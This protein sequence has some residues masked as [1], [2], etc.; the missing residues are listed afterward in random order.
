MPVDPLFE[1]VR[2]SDSP[3]IVKEEHFSRLD[4]PW[5]VHPEYELTLIR[6]QTVGGPVPDRFPGPGFFP[7][8]GLPP[9]R[10]SS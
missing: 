8:S 5:H 3:F 7:E 2:L 9:D 4:I 10:R 6:F 1:K